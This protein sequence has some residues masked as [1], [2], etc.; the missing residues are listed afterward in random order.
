MEMEK[1]KDNEKKR[2]SAMSGHRDHERLDANPAVVAG[3]P[4]RGTQSVHKKE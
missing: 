2:E 4:E 1:K 3:F